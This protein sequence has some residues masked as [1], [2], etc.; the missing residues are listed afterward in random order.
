MSELEQGR[1]L[2]RQLLAKMSVKEVKILAE[3][4][5]DNFIIE[6][7][8]KAVIAALKADYCI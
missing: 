6:A 2:L 1:I 8:R 7:G 3:H 4:H 5:I